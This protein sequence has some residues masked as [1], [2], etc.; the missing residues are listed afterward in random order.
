MN[1]LLLN[2]FSTTNMFSSRA[3]GS[4]SRNTCRL[5]CVAFQEPGGFG[6][7]AGR[8]AGCPGGL[9]GFSAAGPGLLH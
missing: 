3:A 4:I 9:P 5:F 6:E 1:S 7:R 8:A 2:R